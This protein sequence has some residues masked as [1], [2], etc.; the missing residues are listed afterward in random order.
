MSFFRDIKL[1]HQLRR[2]E[3]DHDRGLIP[4]NLYR[5]H[6]STLLVELGE[7]RACAEHCENYLIAASDDVVIGRL[8]HCYGE[9]DQWEKAADTYRT[10]EDVWR[11]PLDALGLALAELRCGNADRTVEILE[12]VEPTHSHAT[13]PTEALIRQLRSELWWSNEEH[14]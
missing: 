12:I 2:L 11:D 3:R 8:A 1:R 7:Y 4:S 5:L 6:A 10:M 14:E 13:G 9:M